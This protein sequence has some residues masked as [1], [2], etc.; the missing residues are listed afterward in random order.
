M[1][2]FNTTSNNGLAVESAFEELQNKA[3]E[4]CSAI[5]DMKAMDIDNESWEF[6]D[7]LW[8]D[9]MEITDR[10]TKVVGSYDESEM[11]VAVVGA[12]I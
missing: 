9:C 3:E 6:L 12:Q 1:I 4:L 5:D 7:K 2:T 10:D 8:N 11:Y